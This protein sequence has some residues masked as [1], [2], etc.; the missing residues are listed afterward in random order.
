MAKPA[1]HRRAF[2][3]FDIDGNRPFVAIDKVV[4][5]ERADSE[6]GHVARRRLDLDDVRAEVRKEHRAPRASQDMS[7]VNDS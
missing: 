1:Q 4:G 3:P 2:G 6:T 7:A 5:V